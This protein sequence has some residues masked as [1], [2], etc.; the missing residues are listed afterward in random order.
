MEDRPPNAQI[1]ELSQEEQATT[2]RA[3]VESMNDGFGMINEEGAF[4]YVNMRFARMLNYRPAADG[5]VTQPQGR[6]F[7]APDP[8][9]GG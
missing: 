8:A 6:D 7:T 3:L 5:P 1:P 2:Y 9:Q 4:T